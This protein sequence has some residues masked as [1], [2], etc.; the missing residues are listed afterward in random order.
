MSLEIT[1]SQLEL[2]VRLAHP[3]AE[4]AEADVQRVTVGADLRDELRV[5]RYADAHHLRLLSAE[6]LRESGAVGDVLHGL[7]AL[8]QQLQHDGGSVPD[9]QQRG[10]PGGEVG[11]APGAFAV[12]PEVV[13]GQIEFANPAGDPGALLD[14]HQ[15][16]VLAKVL[17]DLAGH[18]EKRRARALDVG[19]ELPEHGLRDLRIVAKPEQDLLLP[20]Q[21]LQQVRLEFRAAGDFQD[22]KQRYQ[23]GGV[24]ARVV[25]GD[26]V[27]GALEQVFQAQQCPDSVV[28]RIL[29]GDHRDIRHWKR[30]RLIAGEPRWTVPEPPRIDYGRAL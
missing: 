30:R 25:R 12:Q 27:I 17:P 8:A 19:N 3:R 28:E 6:H 18:G 22:F 9:R 23:R 4:G 5:E 20:L 24:R 29:V 1:E 11:S 21:F 10:N 7:A 14:R 13:G 16:V 15:P 26:E 2:H